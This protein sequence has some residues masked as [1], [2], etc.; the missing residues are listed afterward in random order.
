ML[1][2]MYLYV[3]WSLHSVVNSE[4]VSEASLRSLLSK[5]TT[6]FEE[7]EYYLNIPPLVEGSKSGNQLACRVSVPPSPLGRYLVLIASNFFDYF[8]TN[9]FLV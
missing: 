8:P 3:A 7:L 6:L 5:R 2:N 1:L 4:V 9:S